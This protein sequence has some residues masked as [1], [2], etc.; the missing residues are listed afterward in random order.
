MAYSDQVVEQVQS[1]NDIVEIIS[2]YIPLKRTG[3]SFKARCPF[4]EEKTPSFVVHP[5][6]QIFH[7]FGC[8]VGGDV[9]SF[10]MK[11][12]QLNF[13]EALRRLAER[14][15]VNLPETSQGSKRERS[16]IERLY[17]VYAAAADFYRANLKHPQLGKVGREYLKSRAF[18][19]GSE[20]VVAA[21]E[22]EHFQLGFAL[23]D[24]RKLFEF[25]SSKGFK[26][27][28]LFRSGLVL[29]SAQGSPYDLFR[30]RVMFPIANA[31]GKVI[32]LGG[33]ALEQETMPKYL[34]SPE[35]PIFRKRR[36]LYALHLAKQAIAKSGEVK[37]A[38]IVEGYLDCIRLHAS[39]F[40]NTVAT[41]GTALTAEHVRVLKRYADEAIVIYDGDKAGEQASLRGLDIFLEEGMS[42]K[43]VCLPQGFDPDDL[44]RTKGQAEMVRLVEARQDFF[45]F[46]LQSL[47]KRFNKG[48]SL[49]LLKIT[50]EFLESFA[51][52]QNPVLV[53]RYL[54]KLA[55]VLGVEE[56]SLRSEL[57]KLKSKQKSQALSAERPQVPISQRPQW[58]EKD[59]PV[60]TLLLSLLLY[61]PSRL[62]T[63]SSLFPDFIFTG[64]VAG[65][66]FNLLKTTSPAGKN[67]FSLSK[68]MNKTDS[69][70]LKAFI[71]RL[72]VMGD[73]SA[74]DQEQAFQDCL[75]KIKSEGRDLR[76]RQMRSQIAR[77]E[78]MGDQDSVQALMRS[79]QELLGKRE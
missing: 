10:L 43:V 55:A 45:D 6:K 39:G 30:N 37:S 15:H 12:E 24:W 46:K 73:F 50:S 1:L 66:V 14:A 17:Q 61:D 75:R 44:I 13:P 58:K 18:G 16:E 57:V 79:Y 33:R 67:N 29:R 36:E 3:R 8:G 2:G 48:D 51:R 42:V 19:D 28:D 68:L 70:A 32:A 7:C 59:P 26:E 5:E 35:S 9:F 54:K 25:L 63:F 69:E 38:F 60:E 23:P 71:T 31:Q 65:E 27:E 62:E 76:L 47:L 74:E 56:H 34:N 49:G 40:A 53:D 72:T 4:H 41:L 77:A 78:E 52:I 64:A 22:I 21:G 20:A 11:Y